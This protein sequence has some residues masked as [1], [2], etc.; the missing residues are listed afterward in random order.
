LHAL[1]GLALP[2]ETARRWLLGLLLAAASVPWAR[3]CGGDA[4]RYLRGALAAV[5]LASPVVE[6]WYVLWIAPFAVLAGDAALL[7]W[8]WAV[9][10]LYVVLDPALMSFRL[11]LPLWQWLWI[12]E[13]G[14]VY[15]LLVP[16]V[17]GGAVTVRPSGRQTAWSRG[18]EGR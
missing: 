4:E 9:G 10:F 6:P 1:L 12:G 5:L 8:S 7:A 15:G 16:R 2:A 14:L 18:Q 11:V 17:L 3:R 13:Y